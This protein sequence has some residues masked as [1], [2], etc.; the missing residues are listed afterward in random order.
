MRRTF[1]YRNKHYIVSPYLQLIPQR[2]VQIWAAC[3]VTDILMAVEQGR[4]QLV[5]DLT[6]HTVTVV[7]TSIISAVNRAM[8]AAAEWNDH[9]DEREVLRWIN[10]GLMLPTDAVET[11]PALYS[12]EVEINRHCNYRCVFC[13]V[14]VKPKAAALMTQDVFDVVLRRALEY[15]IKELSLN[16]YSEP[17]LH[18]NLLEWVSR[19]S[20]S[21]LGVTLFTNGSLFNRRDILGLSRLKNVSIIINLP[22]CN[23]GQYVQVMKSQLMEK[24][25]ANIDEA[26]QKGIPLTLVVN[27]PAHSRS[28][29]TAEV[30]SRFPQEDIRVESW[31]TDDRAGLLPENEYFKHQQHLGLLNGCSLIMRDVSIAWNGNVF[32]CAQ[33][34]DQEYTMGNI[35]EMGLSDILNSPK[36]RQL[37]RWIFGIEESPASFICRRCAWTCSRSSARELFSVGGRDGQ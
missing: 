24:V 17:A 22:T 11:V 6:K 7:P 21:G 2:A 31:P 10:Y 8:T 14:S 30:R 9:I 20:E 1:L 26:H 36:S 16:H 19:A 34:Y 15:G 23:E 33:D 37:R 18:P 3:G 13:P 29:N 5:W 28:A 12:L 4:A 32:L 27:S 25:L 35:L